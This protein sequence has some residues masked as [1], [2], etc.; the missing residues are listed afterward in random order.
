MLHT[1]IIL[2]GWETG[3]G[4]IVKEEGVLYSGGETQDTRWLWGDQAGTQVP[5]GMNNLHVTYTK[6]VSFYVEQV[7]HSMK[8]CLIG[9]STHH[10]WT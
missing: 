2:P 1:A 8:F 3:G 5:G 9:Y 7:F 4:V 6:I 10:V